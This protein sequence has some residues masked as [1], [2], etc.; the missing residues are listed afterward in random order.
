M[1][2]LRI[3][4]QPKMNRARLNRS[5]NSL[6]PLRPQRPLRRMHRRL[7]RLRSA[8]HGR[9]RRIPGLHRREVC[10][11][12]PVVLLRVEAAAESVR[13]RRRR[14][15]WLRQTRLGNAVRYWRV[16]CGCD[17]AF[18]R[19]RTSVDFVSVDLRDIAICGVD[20][21]GGLDDCQ[22]ECRATNR[23]R[24]DAALDSRRHL[25]FA[26]RG[27]A[28]D[29]VYVRRSS[30]ILAGWQILVLIQTFARSQKWLR[31]WG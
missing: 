5:P 17:A 1:S 30:R 28:T 8:T 22:R 21:P 19:A 26:S 6:R 13:L 10:R 16:F 24:R 7:R 29:L 23:R 25:G 31:H 15:L 3:P 20:D 4:R 27:L 11:V 12:L 14:W 9:I 18:E 2:I